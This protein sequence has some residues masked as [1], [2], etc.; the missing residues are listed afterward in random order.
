MTRMASDKGDGRFY[1]S[2]MAQA[3]LLDQLDPTWKQT[4]YADPSLNLADLLRR[5]L[6]K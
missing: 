1:Y 5:A 3:F 4:L 2:G 6:A